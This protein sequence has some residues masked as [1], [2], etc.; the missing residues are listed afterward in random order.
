MFPD[1]QETLFYHPSFWL[2]AAL[3]GEWPFFFTFCVNLSDNQ[4]MAPPPQSWHTCSISL[5]MTIK[6]PT[7]SKGKEKNLKKNWNFNYISWPWAKWVTICLE[8]SQVEKRK[9]HLNPGKTK[10]NF[11]VSWEIYISH[12][13]RVWLK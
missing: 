9:Y 5:E 8:L 10:S 13:I 7:P 4:K 11:K 3:T 2:L 12:N 6:E 1:F